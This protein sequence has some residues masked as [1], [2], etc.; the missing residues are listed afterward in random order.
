MR[1]NICRY[2][3]L[4]LRDLVQGELLG[5]FKFYVFKAAKNI[6]CGV[7]RCDIVQSRAFVVVVLNPS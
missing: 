6:N 5:G 7:P 2:I 4:I 3:K 1:P